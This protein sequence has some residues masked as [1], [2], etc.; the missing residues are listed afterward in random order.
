[1]ETL[2]KLHQIE[3]FIYKYGIIYY[4]KME[5]LITLNMVKENE[6]KL[7]GIIFTSLQLNI[8]KKRLQKKQLSSNEK[9]YY[10]KYIKPKLKAMLSFFD[11]NEINIKGKEH[12]ID[13]RIE[14]AINILNKIKRKH[15]GKKI[16]IS[17]S[18]LFNKNYNDIDVFIFTKYDKEDY[19]KGGIHV[20]F[21]P[22]N[23]I[24]SLFFSSLSEVSISNFQYTPKNEFNVELSNILQNYEFLVN[25]I[26][27]REDYQK[28][29][30][31]FLLNTEYISKGVILNTK[32]LY[33]LRKRI[34]KIKI[35][36][37]MLI[38]A[39]LLRYNKDKLINLKKNISD[40]KGLLKQ[41]K[42]KN[43]DEYIQTYEKVIEL[44][45]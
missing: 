28:E 39:L 27:N 41:Y 40:Y 45:A 30:R 1:M 12:M 44:A 33:L 5:N 7:E 26:L 6:D 43:L 16:M 11:I 13:K 22:E 3:R 8:L 32:Q 34:N 15:K 36:S 20:N 23:A 17:G 35:I 14:T 24:D 29:L 9:T 38:N 19:N 31:D 18:F 37:S 2:G 4:H 25:S 10:Y 42:S 21:L